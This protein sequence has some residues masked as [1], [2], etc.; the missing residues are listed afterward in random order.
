MKNRLVFSHCRNVD[1]DSADVTSE[2]RS[3]HV[4]VTTT[5]KAW[6]ITVAETVCRQNTAAIKYSIAL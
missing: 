5:G 1:N 4:C 2:G 3:F 6:S